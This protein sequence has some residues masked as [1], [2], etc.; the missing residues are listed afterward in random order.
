MRHRS[1]LLASLRSAITC[2]VIRNIVAPPLTYAYTEITW[3]RVQK[4]A[5]NNYHIQKGDSNINGVRN[6][7]F[8]LIFPHMSV[9]L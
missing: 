5:E 3:K 2:D 7:R 9:G 4:N 6:E 1:R 8:Q